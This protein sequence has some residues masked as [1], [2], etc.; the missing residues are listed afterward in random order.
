MK[1]GSVDGSTGWVVGHR[2]CPP[3]EMAFFDPKAQQEVMGRDVDNTW[4]ASP[5][6]PMGVA[7][8][9]D[10]GYTSTAAGRSPPATTTASGS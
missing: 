4:I 9:V 1:L 10:G 6:A 8:P 5:Y 2:R 3:W 7:V